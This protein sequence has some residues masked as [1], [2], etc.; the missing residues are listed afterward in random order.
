MA[1][2]SFQQPNG[3]PTA[4]CIIGSC[5]LTPGQYA[6]DDRNVLNKRPARLFTWQLI[7]VMM[8]LRIESS[9]AIHSAPNQPAQNVSNLL[10]K[11]MNMNMA[12]LTL[13]CIVDLYCLLSSCAA[14]LNCNPVKS[15][16]S[17]S[18]EAPAQFFY[19]IATAD[20]PVPTRFCDPPKCTPGSGP[21]R[22]TL[23]IS[24]CFYD[25]Y[26]RYKSGPD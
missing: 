3:E 18:L 6:A 12:N 4:R 24:G 23:M 16:G 2:K 14:H 26:V 1:L 25:R 21:A 22:F 8:I 5:R 9:L 10:D 13:G 7:L 17:P 19:S 11:S 15:S 20:K